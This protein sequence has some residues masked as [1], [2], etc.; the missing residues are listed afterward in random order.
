MIAAMAVLYFMGHREEFHVI[1]TVS[2]G[3]VVLLS[4]LQ[5][6]SGIFYGLQ[7]KVLTDHYKLNLNFFQW[8]GL[9]R[10]TSFANLWLPSGAGTSVKALYLKKVHNL[11]YSSFIALTAVMNLIKFMVNSFFACMLLLVT[12]RSAPLFLFVVSFALFAVTSVSVLLAHRISIRFFSSWDFLKKVVEEWRDIR[13]DRAAVVKLILVSCLIF[14]VAG[15]QVFVSFRAFAFDLSFLTGGLI[16]AC[17]TV[18]GVIALIPGNFG[19]REAIIVGISGIDGIGVNEGIHAAALS[20]ITGIV[21]TLLLSSFP[22]YKFLGRQE[23]FS[24]GKP[25]RT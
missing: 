12:I 15:A 17:T 14:V 9:I 22:W 7:L 23:D 6:F 4:I 19:I 13:K 18:A 1:G 10:A 5:L 24:S 3:A 11:D 16:A 2:V 21:W 20:R 25:R 8:Y